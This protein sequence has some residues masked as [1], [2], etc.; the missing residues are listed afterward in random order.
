VSNKSFSGFSIDS[1]WLASHNDQG[2]FGVALCA[3]IL[4]FLF[5][6]AYF[7]ARGA[8]RALALFLIT[9]VLMT[10]FTEVT[11]NDVSPYL[12]DLTVAASLL[13]APTATR[14]PP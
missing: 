7:Q 13:V 14:M 11:F 5:V 12:L 1:N 4:V 10:S 8:E 2:L 9:Y 3:T 6:N